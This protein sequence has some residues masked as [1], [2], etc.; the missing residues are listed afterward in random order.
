MLENKDTKIYCFLSLSLAN[1]FFYNIMYC[2]FIVVVVC[3]RTGVFF[4]CCLCR[5]VQCYVLLQLLDCFPIKCHWASLCQNVI[6][7]SA[8]YT[9]SSQIINCGWGEAR[10]D[11][12][13]FGI[14]SE[15]KKKKAMLFFFFLNL[16]CDQLE[17]ANALLSI[18][19][20]SF[21]GIKVIHLPF[22]Y[23]AAQ[24]NVSSCPSCYKHRTY[25]YR[26]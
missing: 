4:F 11:V 22:Y 8:G 14:F 2:A 25:I 3:K 15:G 5:T 6:K 1:L 20:S 23:R 13:R 12:T 19:V 9:V 7:V 21:Y 18:K 10:N 17:S 24:W 26:W 16:P